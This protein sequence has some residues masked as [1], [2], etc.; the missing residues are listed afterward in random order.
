[1]V[2]FFGTIIPTNASAYNTHNPI[3]ING[4][5][6]F[7]S[8]NGVTGGNGTE[9]DPYMIEGW[10]INASSANGIEIRNTDAYFIIRNCYV[11]DG[12]YYDN[13]GIYFNNV[14]N[15][16]VEST[17]SMNNRIGVYL[18]SS[19]R[20]NLYGNNLSDNWDW[21]ICLENSSNNDIYNNDAWNNQD[22]DLCYSSAGIFL[23]YSSSNNIHNNIASTND[24]GIVL[25]HSSSNNN[26]HHNIVSNNGRGISLYSSSNNNIHNNTASNNGEDGV[27]LYSSS[28]NSFVSNNI[29]YNSCCVEIYSSSSKNNTFHHNNFVSSGVV[30]VINNGV[31]TKWDN[32]HGE[33]N[34]WSNYTGLDDGSNGRVVGD[35]VG[36][37]DIPHMGLDNYPLME[38]MQRGKSLWIW[39]MLLLIPIILIIVIIVV[40]I[41]KPR[42]KK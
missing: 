39:I 9:S 23:A 31:N 41:I 27:Y 12:N 1:M 40:I 16:V 7:T 38:P 22:N 19:N 15:G 2:I 8:A 4:N 17:I 11:H 24:W 26:I 34:Y 32:G 42:R 5:E 21:G 10:D 35:G 29:S 20:N 30:N 33:G 36:D 14:Q 37:T 25:G 6:N 13:D 28:Y 3:Y 18:S